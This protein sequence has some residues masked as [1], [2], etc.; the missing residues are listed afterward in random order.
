MWRR[1]ARHF[2]F[3]LNKI[4]LASKQGV[5]KSAQ[6]F[7]QS[8]PKISG[9]QADSKANEYQALFRN[10]M[11]NL[12]HTQYF[13]AIEVLKSMLELLKDEPKE[14]DYCKVYKLGSF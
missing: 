8:L 4:S 1:L 14:V 2:S 11:D 6:L 7:P 3:K 5:L 12:I 10:L 9:V 13:E